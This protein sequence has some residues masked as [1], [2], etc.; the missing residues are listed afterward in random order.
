M[1]KPDVLAMSRMARSS[2]QDIAP[3]RPLRSFIRGPIDKLPEDKGDL[4]A[5]LRRVASN[6]VIEPATATFF[7]A[8]RRRD[9]VK[10]PLVTQPNK[11]SAAITKEP[12]PKLEK[13]IPETFDV[14]DPAPLLSET[15]KDYLPRVA[16]PM[17]RKGELNKIQYTVEPLKKNVTPLDA[18]KAGGKRSKI[19]IGGG[20]NTFVVQ[21]DL[22][23]RS[24]GDD[25]KGDD[26][27]QGDSDSG[28]APPVVVVSEDDDKTSASAAPPSSGAVV[29]D[30]QQRLTNEKMRHNQ[31]NITQVKHTSMAQPKRT[32]KV[33]R[34]SS[35]NV[36]TTNFF[37]PRTPT[38]SAA[39]TPAFTE[40]FAQLSQQV[41]RVEALHMQ[42]LRGLDDIRQTTSSGF[43]SLSAQSTSLASRLDEVSGK[44]DQILA[45]N[46]QEHKTTRQAISAEHEATRWSIAEHGMSA[47]S[48]P[49][50][51]APLSEAP[52]PKQ[53]SPKQPSPKVASPSKPME[54][55]PREQQLIDMTA[56]A[57]DTQDA[58]ENIPSSD[59]LLGPLT[60]LSRTMS[61][62]RNS[63]RLA[64]GAASSATQA[65]SRMHVDA[66]RDDD[67]TAMPP[68][69]PRRSRSVS[70]ARKASETE[71]S[72]V[73]F[74]SHLKG[75]KKSR[76]TSPDPSAAVS[77]ASSVAPSAASSAT[78]SPAAT[79]RRVTR[80]MS[81]AAASQDAQSAAD[82][83][84]DSKSTPPS[85]TTQSA[86]QSNAK[87]I[88]QKLV[89]DKYTDANNNP[90]GVEYF[91]THGQYHLFN[92]E[93]K[94]I[95]S[96]TSR[97]GLFNRLT[98]D[99]LE[100][101]AS[102]TPVWN[103]IQSLLKDSGSSVVMLGNHTNKNIGKA[104]P[105]TV[106]EAARNFAV[107]VSKP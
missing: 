102:A 72:A 17:I 81:R 96:F 76:V 87:E 5:R 63:P 34:L 105:I 50:G 59:E 70:R 43:Q 41:G 24:T 32:P 54:A 23:R 18:M 29:E 78:A 71:S 14:K 69:P 77:T 28:S 1:G 47:D 3:L 56:E 83:S 51:A 101:G 97:S 48:S 26:G 99:L 64:R 91:V 67:T 44:S 42:S 39:P 73:D 62:Q 53:P 84:D 7:D 93:T 88:V 61:S 65:Q 31:Q 4:D 13:P 103:A 27:K 40:N 2:L 75:Q 98:R 85:P 6:Q 55:S 21:G 15:A 8:M 89:D 66:K 38:M 20:G 92:S 25:I 33:S 12:K 16:K 36:T 37:A 68:P 19:P 11:P 106:K 82:E 49:Q 60:Q 90:I 9:D 107:F 100:T 35:A 30:A 45:Q 79:G 95:E 10:M 74:E 52:S 57:M 86:M 22:V 46:A 104:K 94:Q 80:S 58:L